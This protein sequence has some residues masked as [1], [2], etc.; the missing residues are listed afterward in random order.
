MERSEGQASSQHIGQVT[1]SAISNTGNANTYNIYGDQHLHQALGKPWVPPL[2]LPPRAQSFVGREEEIDW[3]LQ[4]LRKEEMGIVLGLCGAGGM[5]KTALAAEAL[6]RLVAQEEWLVDFPDGIFY[7]SFYT[8]PS[9][10]V[11]FEELARLFEEE[12]GAD[13][14]R[15]AVRALSR[16]CALLVF[17]GVEVLPDSRPLRELGGKN[18]V[19]LLSRRQSDVPDR[20]HRRDLQMLSQEQGM[21]LLQELAGPR[22]ADRSCLERL[23]K[24]ISGY[25]LALQLIG[26][27]LSS[28]QEEVGEYLQWF[29]REGLAALDFGVHPAESVPV[30]LQRTYT[31]LTASE[32]EV[33]VLLGLLAPA[34]FPLELVQGVLEHHESI[35]RPA[36]SSLVNLSILR[37]PSQDY[38]VSHSLV[39]TFA[40]E[41]L[42]SQLPATSPLVASRIAT[43]W[44]RF[45]A[46]LI[47]QYEQVDPYD[48]TALTLWYPHVLPFLLA[49][50]LTTEQLLRAAALFTEVG[51]AASY[52]GKYAEAEPLLQ[53]ALVIREEQL[54][55]EHPD[56]AS[57]LNNLAV[58]YFKQGKY[59]EAESLYQQALAIREE[60]LGAQ[61]PDTAQSLNNLA[62]LYKNQGKYEQ[63][64]PLYQRSLAIWE[65]RGTSHPDT[66]MSLSNLALLY[67]NQ[68]KYE[69]AEPLF[70]RALAIWEEQLGLSHPDTAT[71]LDNLAG[72]YREQGKYEQAE[73]LY[74]RALAIREEQLGP[75]HPD[76]AY[77]LNNLALLYDSQGKYE[78]AEPLCRRALTI[79]EQRL[80]SSHPIRQI[81]RK[82][83]TAVL[84]AMK[85]EGEADV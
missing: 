35:V 85:V 56:T 10:P 15:A 58:L 62:V 24:Q 4:Q 23:V 8:S 78:Q 76:T 66:A 41:Q 40:K 59:A 5:G 14:R 81:I 39:H 38:E 84:K 75:T 48:A 65:E 70:K 69:Q 51:I 31:S 19:L 30:L 44:E 33:F 26:S 28:R 72:V 67:I 54:G 20:A 17:D 47:H 2:M 6:A 21:R 73:P 68:G 32:Q 49:K 64:E 79:V 46:T 11:A 37:R 60:R 63:A 36:L 74:W 22:A 45:L 27:Y 77:C 34:P 13:P 9:L 1:N 82:N 43:W 25:P 12:P 61:H 52:Q 57:S 53:R 50:Y 16:R 29:E 18:R 7:H 71:C 80:A 3:L 42:L 55:T 83:Y